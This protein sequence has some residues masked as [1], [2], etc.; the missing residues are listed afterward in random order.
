VRLGTLILAYGPTVSAGRARSNTRD[1]GAI[2]QVKSPWGRGKKTAARPLTITG[3]ISIDYL[4]RSRE[5]LQEARDNMGKTSQG[6]GRFLD[7]GGAN[8]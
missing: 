3:E 4:P 8:L 2:P 1:A 6:H 5:K 7:K